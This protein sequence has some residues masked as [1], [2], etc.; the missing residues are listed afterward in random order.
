MYQPDA[1][2]AYTAKGGTYLVTANEGDAR[3]WP[4]FAE[5]SRVS[6]LTLDP[7]RSRT[8][9]RCKQNANLGRLTVTTALGDTD[10]DGDYEQL[11]TLGGRSFSIWSSTGAQ[12]YDSGSDFERITAFEQS[13]VLQ[14]EQRQQQLRRPLRQQGPGA[15]GRGAGRDRRP[16]LRV[17]RPRAVRRR[18]D[19]RRDRPA[20]RRSSSTTSTTATF[21]AGTG[22]LGP[23]G[24]HFIPATD[25]PNGQ[26]LLV[27][28]NEVSG[29]VTLYE[30]KKK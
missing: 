17:R 30:V 25:S 20:R 18:H 4:G 2:A 16:H 3:D 29:T 23:E 28:A 21:A 10:G 24:V 5:E 1:I 13:G 19:V 22:D 7:T 26:P 12:V 11:F 8:A 27:V 15:G 9:R 14:R 6:A